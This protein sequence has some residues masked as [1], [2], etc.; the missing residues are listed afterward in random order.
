MAHAEVYAKLLTNFDGAKLHLTQHD[1]AILASFKS[2]F[3]EI[4]VSDILK[5][6]DHFNTTAAKAKWEKWVTQWAPKITDAQYGS[7]SFHFFIMI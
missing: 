2:E 5:G 1:D 6:G 7:M 4:D 3:P